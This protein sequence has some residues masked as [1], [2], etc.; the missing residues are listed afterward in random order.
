MSPN[1]WTD[2]F[3]CTEWVRESFVPQVCQHRVFK[4]PIL[5]LMDGHGSQITLEMRTLALEN[6]IHLLCLPPHTKHCLQPLD[7]G[8]FGPLQAAWQDHCNEVLAN[9]GQEICRGDFI[10]EYMAVV[11]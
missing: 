1:G 3:L 10:R 9:T 6:N 2:D 4:A 7:V 11:T 8:F 5:L